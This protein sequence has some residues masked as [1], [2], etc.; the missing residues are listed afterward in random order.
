MALHEVG[1]FMLLR[2]WGSRRGG[3]LWC[4]SPVPADP[5]AIAD[6]VHPGSRARVGIPLGSS[7][8]TQG[9]SIP[10]WVR[11]EWAR[12]PPGLHVAAAALLCLRGVP[13]LCLLGAAAVVLPG[14]R[15]PAVCGR[16]LAAGMVVGVRLCGSPW[17]MGAPAVVLPGC[18]LPLLRGTCVV[19]ASVVLGPLLSPLLPAW[20]RC[21][22]RLL[23]CL[24]SRWVASAVVPL[25]W[26]PLG[27]CCLALSSGGSP[28]VLVGGCCLAF[29]VFSVPPFVW[30]FSAALLVRYLPRRGLLAGR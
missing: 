4:G 8:E 13:R 3:L 17:L 11:V 27:C 2:G 24:W 21:R 10:E 29:L 16:G 19:G 12:L 20:L 1:V 6:L 22:C 30:G 28:P 23:V 18:R 25:L 5:A 14:C 9:A 26:P 7:A 15:L